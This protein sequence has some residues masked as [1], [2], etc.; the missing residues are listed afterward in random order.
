MKN[1]YSALAERRRKLREQV[2]LAR[3]MEMCKGYDPMPVKTFLM[4][5]RLPTRTIRPR[6]HPSAPYRVRRALRR[7]ATKRAPMP[8]TAE[9]VHPARGG[10]PRVHGA[11]RG[12]HQH[13][14]RGARHRRH[15]TRRVHPLL[16]YIVLYILVYYTRGIRAHPLP[17][18]RSACCCWMREGGR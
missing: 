3:F 18:P 8:R 14:R 16:H 1:S 5:V 15:H 4:R 10:L 17:S 7:A 2:Q 11:A 12:V 13:A 9:P 6:V